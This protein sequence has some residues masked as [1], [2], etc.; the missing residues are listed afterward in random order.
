[1]FGDDIMFG[2]FKEKS[3]VSSRP[4]FNEIPSIGRESERPSENREQPWKREDEVF[5][6]EPS[7]ES[8]RPSDSME[9]P[10]KRDGEVFN[11][12]PTHELKS[13]IKSCP[14]ENGDWTGERGNSKW[15]PDKNYV[16]LKSN[17]EQKTWGEIMEKHGI[18][19]IDF[20]DGEPNFESISKGTVEIEGFSESRTDNFDKADIELAKAKGCSPED[21]RQ[22]RKENGYTWHECRD[23]KTMQKTSSMVHNNI[24]HSGGISAIKNGG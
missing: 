4:V 21:V 24:S 18:D 8:E 7:Y 20:K 10:W 17:S 14:V 6:M 5:R 15:C 19:G 22:W 2:D 23:M 9:Q 11:T 16:P 1:M 12:E 3:D 13:D